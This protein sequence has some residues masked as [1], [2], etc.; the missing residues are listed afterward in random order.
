MEITGVGCAREASVGDC[1]G[2]W[3]GDRWVVCC[4][5]AFSTSIMN[6]FVNE[7]PFCVYVLCSNACICAL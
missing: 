5:N 1:V 4:I 7:L 2:V 3:V 6:G